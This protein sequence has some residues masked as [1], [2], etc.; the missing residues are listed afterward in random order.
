V[1]ALPTCSSAAVG[2]LR[3][4][5]GTGRACWAGCV[6]AATSGRHPLTAVEEVLQV[7]LLLP[8]SGLNLSTSFDSHVT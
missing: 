7:V 2:T 1:A 8:P 6:P 4:Q 3:A 5:S